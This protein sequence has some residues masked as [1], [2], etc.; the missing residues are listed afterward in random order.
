MAA[1]WEDEERLET[2][3]KNGPTIIVLP[4]LPFSFFLQPPAL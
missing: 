4:L 3:G 2:G 1:G